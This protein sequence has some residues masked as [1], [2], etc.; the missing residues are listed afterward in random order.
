[1]LNRI[2]WLVVYIG[3]VTFDI[4]VYISNETVLAKTVGLSCAVLTASLFALELLIV[5]INK[6]LDI[7]EN[8]INKERK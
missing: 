5:Y 8:K 2:F 4:F 7:L 6:R 1:M 3:F